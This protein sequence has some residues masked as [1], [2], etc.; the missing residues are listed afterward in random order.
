MLVEVSCAA[1][2]L[3]RG[4]CAELIERSKANRD[5]NNKERLDNYNRKNFK[6]G[7]SYWPFLQDMAEQR[8]HNAHGCI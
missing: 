3:R 4:A 8:L 5:K 6:V 1:L 2:Q 7:K